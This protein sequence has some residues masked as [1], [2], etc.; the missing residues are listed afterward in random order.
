M[1]D[2]LTA[3]YETQLNRLEKAGIDSTDIDGTLLMHCWEEEYLSSKYKMLFVGQESNKWM[4]KFNLDPDECLQ[5]YKNFELCNNGTYTTFWQYIYET[6]NILMKDTIG[7][8][9][10]LWSN[11]S[12]FSTLSGKK[13][14]QNKFKAIYEHFH[15]LEAEIEITKPDVVIFFSGHRY[16]PWI[17]YQISD[18]I[19]YEPVSK[20]IPTKDLARLT[21]KAFPYHTYRLAHPGYLQRSGNWK[22]VELIM[23]EIRKTDQ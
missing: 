15:V 11:V 5:R 17:Q 6:K 2:Q 7:Q 3:L 23:D 1:N 9:N 14:G 20:D 8:K 4:G 21:S 13:L 18:T 22:Y 12:K 16:D 19:A 10:F